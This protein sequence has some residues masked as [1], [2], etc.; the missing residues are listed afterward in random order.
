MER[1]KI[2]RNHPTYTINDQKLMF[3][4]FKQGKS[5]AEIH[6]KFPEKSKSAIANKL[7]RMGLTR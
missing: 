6:A 3:D 1:N 5:L 4:M 2:G 7:T